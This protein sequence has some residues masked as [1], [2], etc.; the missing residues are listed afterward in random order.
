MLATRD[1]ETA[2]SLLNNDKDFLPDWP[3][4][5]LT[6]HFVGTAELQVRATG[7]GQPHLCSVASSAS[8]LQLTKVCTG[9]NFA[10]HVS[11]NAQQPARSAD[12]FVYMQ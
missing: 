6:A 2:V 4:T 9:K 1:P 8:A 3:G 7:D 11:V 10:A 12:G 5:L